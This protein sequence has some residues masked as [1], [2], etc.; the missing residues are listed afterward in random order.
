LPA[1]LCSHTIAAMQTPFSDRLPMNRVSGLRSRAGCAPWF[2]RRQFWAL[3]FLVLIGVPPLQAS[4]SALPAPL[5]QAIQA[6]NLP[7]DAVGLWV[8]RVGDPEALVS[9]NANR[10]FNPAS[11]IK[12]ATT[13]AALAALGPQHTWQTE[14]LA[15]KPLE[16]DVLRGDLI[17]RGSGDPGMVS[18]EHWRMLGALR[19]AGLRRIDGDVILDTSVFDLLPEDPGAFDGQ[20]LRAYNQPPFAL[21]VNANA[22][23]FHVIPD[24]DG[25]SIRIEADPPLPGLE[26]V[27]QL[28]VSRGD[29]GTWQRGI[30][31]EADVGS[32]APRAV[33]S[34]DYPVNCG[35]FELLRIAV[36][37][38]IYHRELFRLHWNQWGGEL[39]GDVRAGL[40]PTAGLTPLM[41]HE[42]R[43]LAEVIRIAN[44]WSSNVVTRHLAL[45]L[46]AARLG[47]PATIE[48]ARQALYEVLAEQGVNVGGMV[49]DNG[50][51][52]SRHTRITPLQM[53]EVLQAGWNSPWRPEFISSLALA[54]LD[55]TLRRR[56][57][58][59]PETGRMHLKTGHLREVSSV[60][61]YVRNRS[62]D[63]VMVVLMIN[64]PSAHQ[65]PGTNLQEA[66]LR[67]VHAL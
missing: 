18:E 37:P 35:N 8:Q 55:G 45:T 41:V 9:L 6:Q 1:A 53:A 57:R 66:I 50:S 31:Y 47:A 29:C 56:F 67:W 46:G 13:L 27:N 43:P 23:R 36:A 49:I 61:G 24:A 52:L 59:G 12:L 25:R 17:L 65:G 28:R 10:M 40:A 26:I 62:G 3:L 64:H 16:G 22:L 54:G 7:A 21:H 38:E 42:S 2:R 58:E 60:A 39:T 44:K 51:G 4:L 5:Q 19:R 32:G 14:I 33:F 63:D 34:G 48:K 11:T 15:T 30:R 20:P